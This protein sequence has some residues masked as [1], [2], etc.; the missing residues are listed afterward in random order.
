MNNLYNQL[1]QQVNQNLSF[2]N[3]NLMQIKN[4]MN[5]FKNA[6][7]PQAMLQTLMQQ[8]PQIKQVMNFV[9]QSGG[10]PKTAFYNL[11]KQQGVDPNQILQMLN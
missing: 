7:N 8:N 10:D 9:Q 1:N 4:M 6:S 11:A 5:M 2:P 3:N